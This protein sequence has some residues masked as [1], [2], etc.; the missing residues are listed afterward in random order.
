MNIQTV[1]FCAAILAAFFLYR[2]YQRRQAEAR[3]YFDALELSE[4]VNELAAIMEQLDNA[5]RMMIDLEACK[6]GML[7]RFFH[8][9]WLSSDGRNRTIDLCATGRGKASRGLA[10]AARAERDRLN[11]EVIDRIR[12]LSLAVDACDASQAT[13]CTPLSD[14]LS[15]AETAAQS[16]TNDRTNGSMQRIRG[17]A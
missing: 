10:A 13:I 12:A 17:S 1:I 15:D 2:W 3:Q 7:H 6:P 4:A 8:A 9:S 11:Q 16:G 14:D 5:D